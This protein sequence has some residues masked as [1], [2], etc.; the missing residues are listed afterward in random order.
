MGME[1]EEFRTALLNDPFYLD[2]SDYYGQ[3]LRWLEYFPL[4]SFLF[5][6]FEDLKENPVRVVRDCYKFLGVDG[7]PASIRL[8]SAQ[9][10]SYQVGW[11]GRRINRI[12]SRVHRL[13][14]THPGFRVALR[15]IVPGSV[16]R[17]V[18]SAKVGS[19]PVPAMQE[20]DRD[21]LIEYFRG[22]NRNLER[23][24]GTPLDRWQQ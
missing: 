17:A 13:G 23:L 21:F 20:G 8:H 11:V 9:N 22:R 24:I 12:G 2:V 3:L 5:V 10:Q 1:K 16:R 7:E 14:V 15:S 6:L 4:R 18:N 19:T